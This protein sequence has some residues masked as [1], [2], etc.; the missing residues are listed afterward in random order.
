MISS[1]PGCKYA[2]QAGSAAS[3]L[4]TAQKIVNR[5][6]NNRGI[7]VLLS[8]SLA[9]YALP[10]AQQS[11]LLIYVQLGKSEKL[12]S[13]RR[14]VDEAGF[15]NS[16][17]YVEA[18]DWA[19]IHLADNIAD[20]LV[21]EGS[22]TPEVEKEI[23]RV[24][25]PEAVALLGDRELVKPFPKNTDDWSHPFHGPDNNPQSKD[26]IA[27]A[28]YLTQ[29]L[30]EPHYAPATQVAV[31][32]SGRLFKGFGS[33]AWHERE[34]AY[35]NKLVAFNGYNGALLWQRD[36]VTG[37]MLHRN[38]MIA[39]PEH[40]YVGDDKSCKLYNAKTG[41]LAG[42]IAVDAEEAGG[43]FWKW[44]GLQD[45][46]LYALIGEQEAKDPVMRWQRQKHGW[47]WDAISPGFNQE[48]NPWGFGRDFFAIH[49]VTKKTKWHYHE[50][51]AIDSRALCMNS[52]RVYLFRFGAYL[53]CLDAH[54]GKKLWRKTPENAPELFNA[55]GI[56]LNRQG[57][58]TN[59]RTRN[60][61]MCSDEALYFAG[62]QI[63]KLLAVSAKDGSV[64]WENPFNNF[65]LVLRD[66]GLYAIAGIW[67]NHASK[68]F[69]PLTGAVIAD[70]ATARRA[71]TRPTGS[72]DAILYR[73][74]DG[75]VR[76]DMASNQPQWIS[77]MRPPCFDGVTIANGFLYWWPY[78]CDCQL[79]IYG[80]TAVGPAGSFDFYPKA[81][82]SDRLDI[83]TSAS[84]KNAGMLLNQADWCSF[85]KNNVADATTPAAI[86]TEARAMW[87]FPAR[88]VE[89]AGTN[90]LG[91]AWQATLT[92]PVTADGL[93]FYSGS[94]GIVRCL[95]EV[96]GE[97]VWKAYTGGVVRFPPTIYHDKVLVGSGDGWVNCYIARTGERVWSF[98]AA[99]LERK[100]PVYGS[101][102]STWPAAS[103]ILVEDGVAY[104]ASGIVNYDGTY[105][106]ALDAETGKIRW[107]NNT[108]GHLL[109][110]SKTGASVQ[111]H[112]LIHDGKLYL[113]G[114]TSLSPVVYDIKTGACLNDPE[115]LKTCDSTHPRGSELYLVGNQVYACGKPFY[116]RPEE[117]VFDP[118]VTDKLLHT[119]VGNRDIVWVNQSRLMAL[120]HVDEQTLNS[121][122]SSGRYL[123]FMAPMW[124]K[125]SGALKP[126]WEYDCKGSLAVAV[127]S[128]AVAVAD[129]AELVVLSVQNGQVLWRQPLDYAPVPWGIAT[130]RAGR[131]LLTL[132][133]GSVRCFGGE[134]TAPTPF[135]SSNNSYFV[136]ST[137]LVLSCN[138]K[139][140]EIR[141]TLDGSEPT[142][143]SSLYSR[144][145]PVKEPGVLHMRAYGKNGIAGYVV[146]EPLIKVAF[147]KAGLSLPLAPGIQFKYYEGSFSQVADIDRGK[148]AGSG[149]LMQFVFKPRGAVE[150]FG[151]AYDGYL[152]VP[153]DG[154]YTFYLESN[155]GSRLYL[156]DKELINND[157]PHGAIEKSAKMALKKGA[158]PLLVKY[159]QMGGAKALRV[160]W[161]GPGIEKQE[162]TAQALF[163]KP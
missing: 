135:I 23:M 84:L 43:T 30:A 17:I 58:E 151:Y 77:P 154:V 122:V 100:I 113:A 119:R 33:I 139:D 94:D 54:S 142:Q 36:M 63:N 38:T 66:D 15:L 87:R 6:E 29:F 60:Y 26:K 126:A 91:H 37:I 79:S 1:G 163:H 104:V 16:R 21:L 86:A 27:R 72:A 62:P 18:G 55:I 76:L 42:E 88:Q 117:M 118:T 73:A 103:G 132:E 109:A 115:P 140:A 144:P 32:S 78:V 47:P 143:H 150:E 39:T 106:F 11:E 149:I 45:G 158:Y 112:M 8:D 64:L 146:S 99:P 105:V 69:D 41:E 3:P 125:L 7:C 9:D 145:I 35:L 81:T 40:L 25:H 74:D 14:R 110:E 68:K 138:V 2:K 153:R 83:N 116:S 89:Y 120:P 13:C 114:G 12:E 5:L 107:Q 49:P 34:E 123:G 160:S 93:V 131:V 20:I 59:W 147:E 70:L 152:V 98:R 80:L 95:D 92:A 50:D 75:T 44:M 56:Y 57:W 159:F 71:C 19:H 141:Y 111:G 127:G 52:E 102:L 28:P 134:S 96:T 46:V 65:Q 155:D 82:E 108:S 128:N 31:A 10:L 24:L 4:Q 137:R 67:R 124:K 51:E 121:S 22:A 130:S 129:A 161:D 157:G 136:D 48:E 61:V 90:V 162:L 85:R 133:D 53:T 101:L 148:L 156:N 97:Q